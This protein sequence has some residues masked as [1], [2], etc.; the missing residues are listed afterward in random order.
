MPYTHFQYIAYQIPTVAEDNTRATIYGLP[1]A[2][3]QNAPNLD[4][5]I[6]NLNA[7]ARNRVDRLIGAMRLAEARIQQLGDNDHTLKIFLAPE[8][9]FRPDVRLVSG[10][11]RWVGMR[12]RLSIASNTCPRII[13]ESA[14]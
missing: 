5:P 7:D 9:Y 14:M 10:A 13:R 11:A 8:F 12:W 1:S 3:V 6:A 2:P 4:G